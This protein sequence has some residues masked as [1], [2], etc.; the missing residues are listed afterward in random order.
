MKSYEN[1]LCQDRVCHY[2]RGV[3]NATQE[4]RSIS[5]IRDD[6]D[7]D[8]PIKIIAQN[9]AILFSDKFILHAGKNSDKEDLYYFD[10]NKG[11]MLYQTNVLMRKYEEGKEKDEM[12]VLSKE[13]LVLQNKELTYKETI[14]QQEQRIRNLDEA[15]KWLKIYDRFK[16]LIIL[17]G[18]AIGSLSITGIIKIVEYLSR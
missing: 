11:E 5:K 10:P 13:N 15:D 7:G 12:A 2:L 17:I 16:G 14:Q 4:S 18:I 3:W 8:Y 6:I 1:Y 9:C